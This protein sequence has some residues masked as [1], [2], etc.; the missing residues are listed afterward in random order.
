MLLEAFTLLLLLLYAPLSGL[1]AQLPI[2]IEVDIIFPHDGDF[3]AVTN[4]F[5]VIFAVQNSA[6]AYECGL[7]GYEFL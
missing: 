5:P 3:Y 2:C 7:C 4:L 1:S 6:V